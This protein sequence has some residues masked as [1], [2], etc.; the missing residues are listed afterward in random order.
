MKIKRN[1]RGLF[2]SGSI[3]I[4]SSDTMWSSHYK[5]APVI[6]DE[7][8]MSSE[9]LAQ[10]IGPFCFDVPENDGE[11]SDTMRSVEV[12]FHIVKEIIE[13]VRS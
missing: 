7:K 11:G 6:E 12:P 1:W 5:P 4:D 13:A 9:D 10:K 8:K 2:G 3:E